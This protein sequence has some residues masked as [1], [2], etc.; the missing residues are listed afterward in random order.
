VR[1]LLVGAVKLTADD[2]GA[3]QGT[4]GAGTAG[5]TMPF[6]VL[7]TVRESGVGAIFRRTRPRIVWIS[8]RCDGGAEDVVGGRWGFRVDSCRLRGGGELANAFFKVF[9]LRGK[10][11]L[12]MHLVNGDLAKLHGSRRRFFL[13]WRS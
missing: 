13:R 10:R 5:V 1:F 11:L 6:D 8:A 12:S 2:L 3:W 7:K 9:S 4:S